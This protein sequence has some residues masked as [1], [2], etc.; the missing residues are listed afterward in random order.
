MIL[1]YSKLQFFIRYM[2]MHITFVN[3]NY[4]GNVFKIKNLFNVFF[5][6]KL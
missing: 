1:F 2:P 6:I 5:L 3:N 4:K